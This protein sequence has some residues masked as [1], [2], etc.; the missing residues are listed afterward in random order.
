M[1]RNGVKWGIISLEPG[2]GSQRVKFLG[3][4]EPRLD[5]KGRLILPAKFSRDEL[6][7]GVLLPK[8]KSVVF[9]FSFRGVW[10]QSQKR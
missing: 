4:H 3:T 6:A 5:E 7:Q 8:D 9:M 2:E 1:E 10:Q